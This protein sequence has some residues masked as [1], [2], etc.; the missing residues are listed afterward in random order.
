MLEELFL[1]YLRWNIEYD[2]HGIPSRVVTLLSA[3]LVLVKAIR[4]RLLELFLL[5]ICDEVL[6]LSN[7]G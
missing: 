1:L 3:I 7:I 5:Y 4:A 6:T 2:Y